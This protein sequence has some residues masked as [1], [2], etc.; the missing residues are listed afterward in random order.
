MS[1]VTPDIP[2][3]SATR[4]DV[5]SPHPPSLSKDPRKGTWAAL[6]SLY[7]VTAIFGLAGAVS[8]FVDQTQRNDAGFLMD[9]DSFDLNTAGSAVA[10]DPARIFDWGGD[11]EPFD[12]I[13][14]HVS[15][16]VESNKDR[17]VFI[18]LARSDDVRQYL[19]SMA[20][21]DWAPYRSDVLVQNHGGAAPSG[22]P[23]D[24]DFWT[25]SATGSGSQSLRI[26]ATEGRWT[27]VVMNA[28]AT[29]GI[30][31]RASIG[32]EVSS[33]AWIGP[34]LLGVAAATGSAATALL[35]TNRRRRL[36]QG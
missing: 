24:Q 8:V 19:D 17:P 13:V 20:H 33:L 29:P 32:A 11:V 3:D 36:S 18:G 35:L 7:V 12:Q 5:I 10:T 27:V 21:A 22:I 1:V 15:I 14:G 30:D 4:A 28:D 2:P 31:A 26:A 9:D 25:Q 23:M 6:V 34:M 16:T